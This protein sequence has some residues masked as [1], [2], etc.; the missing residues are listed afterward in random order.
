ME[1]ILKALGA[2]DPNLLQHSVRTAGLARKIGDFLNMD[3]E[4]LFQAGL[5]H[6]I[7]KLFV[8]PMIIRKPDILTTEERNMI[9]LHSVFGYQY[10]NIH[11]FS[12]DICEIVLLHHGKFKNHYGIVYSEINIVYADILRACDIYDAMTHDRIYHIRFD[13]NTALSAI[14]AQKEYIPDNIVVSLKKVIS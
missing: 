1:K 6:D 10:L 13:K 4:L 5:V 8:D 9:D 2:F 7:G 14:G 11:G 3:E 12:K